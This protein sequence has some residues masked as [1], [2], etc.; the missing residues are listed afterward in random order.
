[1]EDLHG[2]CP[3]QTDFVV[4]WL[5]DKEFMRKQTNK[6]KQKTT[7]KKSRAPSRG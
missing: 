1:M 4:S 3:H 7:T 6:T 5:K 2:G